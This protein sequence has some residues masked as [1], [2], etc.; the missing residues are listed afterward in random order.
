M[1][2]DGFGQINTKRRERKRTTGLQSKLAAKW[3]SDFLEV[4]NQLYAFHA[5]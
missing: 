1:R 2:K 5:G 4:I 3:G